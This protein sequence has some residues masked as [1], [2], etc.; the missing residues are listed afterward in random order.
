MILNYLFLRNRLKFL[1]ICGLLDLMRGR[2]IGDDEMKKHK[3]RL[4]SFFILVIFII[5]V[6]FSATAAPVQEGTLGKADVRG[7]VR[8]NDEGATANTTIYPPGSVS[9]TL[10]YSYINIHTNVVT[11]ITRG[12]T[13]N[14]TAATS[15]TNPNPRIYRSWRAQGTH[16]ASYAGQTWRANTEIYR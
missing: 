1:K 4:L 12:D 6:P 14:I 3:K 16:T 15:G 9:V 2:N 8:I 13:G 5:L 11:S 10:V 7:E